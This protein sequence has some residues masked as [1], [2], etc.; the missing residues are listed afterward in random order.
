M[1]CSGRRNKKIIAENKI[2]GVPLI[3]QRNDSRKIKQ[4]GLKHIKT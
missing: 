1:L 2:K 4:C 3:I